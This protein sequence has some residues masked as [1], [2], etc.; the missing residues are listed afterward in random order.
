MPK[1]EQILE[2]CR[3]ELWKE[4]VLNEDF[5]VESVQLPAGG[6]LRRVDLG[7]GRERTLARERKELNQGP[8]G[9]SHLQ[10]HLP[11]GLW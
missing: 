5:D 2:I 6:G 3:K 7:M 8:W 9:H 1:A 11:N 4:G 10:D